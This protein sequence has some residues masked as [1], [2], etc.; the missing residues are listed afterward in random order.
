MRIV[1]YGVGA[2]GGVVLGALTRA[3]TPALG[4]ARGARL[5]ALRDRGLRLRAPD[6]DVRVPVDCVETPDDVD[7]RPDDAILLVMKSQDTQ[8]AVEALRAAGVTDQPVFCVQN[9]IENERVALRIL[10]NVHAVNVMLPAEYME[11]DEAIA[12]GTPNFGVFDIGRYPGGT[13]D[14]DHALAAALTDAGI[15]GFATP[16][17]MASKHGKLILNLGNV[18]EAALGRGVEAADIYDAVRDEGRAVLRAA[19]LAFRDVTN[20]QRRELMRIAPV[21]GAERLGSSTTQSLARGAGSVESDWM[22]GE[23][24]LQARLAGTEAPLNAAAARIGARMARD[25][26]AAG[27]MTP[28]AFRR[29][30]GLA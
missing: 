8:G 7:W 3:G 5:A 12:F 20:D 26:L 4:I 10:P 29:E 9:G 2:V 14:A 19:G 17:T 24:A 13:D 6:L 27:S 30:I 15:A 11:A 1:V 25:R 23:I 18:I 16:D 22:N 28:D 21:E